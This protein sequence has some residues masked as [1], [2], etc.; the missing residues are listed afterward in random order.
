MCIRDRRTG[1]LDEAFAV[2]NEAGQIVLSRIVRRGIGPAAGIE[3]A[4][5]HRVP[6]APAG[7][8]KLPNA[9]T[10]A[11]YPQEKLA[12]LDLDDDGDL[13]LIF[14]DGGRFGTDP[15]GNRP[16]LL[17]VLRNDGNGTFVPLP[18]LGGRSFAKVHL[19]AA[20][21][22][23][24]VLTPDEV[25]FYTL[26]GGQLTRLA[27][28]T[29]KKNRPDARALESGD[30]DGDGVED[31]AVLAGGVLEL[32]GGKVAPAGGLGDGGAR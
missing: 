20:G 9:R 11:L 28:P 32:L 2:T 29:L 3:L 13:D 26:T 7:D 16:G 22:A 25:G 18:T 24:A 21:S 14:S 12:L 27:S 4:P 30:F 23:L 8:C 31:L 1:A 6:Y 10:D 19:G 17:V 15:A 5:L